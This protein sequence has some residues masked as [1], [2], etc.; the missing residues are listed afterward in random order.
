MALYSTSVFDRATVGCFLE[1][2]DTRLRPRYMRNPMVERRSDESSTQSASLKEVS[3]TG[4]AGLK[5]SP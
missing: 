1:L 2:H 3:R 5:S 4:D